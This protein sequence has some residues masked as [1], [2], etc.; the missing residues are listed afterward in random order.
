MR[1]FFIQ[2]TKSLSDCSD[3]LADWSLRWAHMSGGT[4]SQFYSI[5][6]HWYIMLPASILYKSIAGRYR[7]VRVA[8]GPITARYRFIKNAYWVSFIPFRKTRLLTKEGFEA[9]IQR[10]RTKMTESLIQEVKGRRI[11]V[12]NVSTSFSFSLE[13]EHF[14]G[15]TMLEKNVPEMMHSWST[16]DRTKKIND[17]LWFQNHCQRRHHFEYSVSLWTLQNVIEKL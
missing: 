15:K 12:V 10:R 3:A 14:K 1:S 8:D 11:D 16:S 17:L 4:F 6:I 5:F 2:T 9:V 13:N 7:P